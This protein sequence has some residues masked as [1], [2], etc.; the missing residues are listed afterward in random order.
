MNWALSFLQTFLLMG[1]LVTPLEMGMGNR[2]ILRTK[3]VS[4]VIVS[5]GLKQL[6]EELSCGM[7]ELKG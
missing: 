5:S 6:P 1:V 4:L 7:S 2:T 3:M